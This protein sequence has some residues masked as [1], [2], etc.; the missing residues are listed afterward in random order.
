[1]GRARVDSR[2]SFICL[3]AA[4][5]LSMYIM[6]YK[7]LENTGLL[8]LSLGCAMSLGKL[9][10][11]SIQR[12]V[13]EHKGEQPL[14]TDGRADGESTSSGRMARYICIVVTGIVKKFEGISLYFTQGDYL[15]N[16][17]CRETN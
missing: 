9:R 1:M 14:Y 3:W 2:S 17:I 7:R 8:P 6:I 11:D 12:N 13:N 5:A 10:H 16:P 15:D 4:S